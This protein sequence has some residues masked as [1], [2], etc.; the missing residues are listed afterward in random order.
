MHGKL[1][2]RIRKNGTSVEWKSKATNNK[3]KNKNE[4][5]DPNWNSYMPKEIRK[6]SRQ[7]VCKEKKANENEQKKKCN[8]KS[9]GKKRT[10]NK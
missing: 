2:F 7:Q 4:A 1:F 9:T 5:S 3:V 6:I 10:K 8:K